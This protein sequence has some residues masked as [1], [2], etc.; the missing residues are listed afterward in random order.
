MAADALADL[1]EV[2]QRFPERRAELLDV[3]GEDLLT[4]V[5]ATRGVLERAAARLDGPGGNETMTET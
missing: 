1:A 3:L 2:L 4:Q 5:E